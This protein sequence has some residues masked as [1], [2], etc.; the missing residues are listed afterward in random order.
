MTARGD[1]REKLI[2][3]ATAEFGEQG[4]GGTDTNRI[5]RRAGFAPQTFDRWFKDKTE[6]F[7][8]VY[9][10]WEDEEVALMRSLRRQGA[11]EADV[12]EAA[13]E[14]HRR[15][16]MFRRS[17][18]RLS[19]EDPQVRAARAQSR[20]RQVEAIRAWRDGALSTET[21]AT[22]LLELER[23]SDALAEG[24]FLDM[25]LGETAARQ[26]LAALLAELR[27]AAP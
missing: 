7:I 9:R 4:F 2:A 8:A 11:G 25:G 18:R 21:V 24:E 14:H 22:T 20:L 12:A 23:L 13:V 17:L 5:A 3:A 27:G 16:L 15:S 10:A 19:L 1:T 26:R 6:I